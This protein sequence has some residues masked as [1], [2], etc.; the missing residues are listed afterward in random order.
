MTPPVPAQPPRVKGWCPGSLRPMMSG[1]GLVLRIKISGGRLDTGMLRAIAALGRRTGNGL[2]DLSHRANL[3]MRGLSDATVPEAL[4][5]LGRLGLLP[6]DEASE[7]VLNVVAPPLAGCDPR[8]AVDGR[9]IVEALEAM[10]RA[11][12]ALHALPGK[13]GFVVDDGA[14]LATTG[15]AADIAI[16]A[17]VEQGAAGVA[18]RLA[19]AAHVAARVAPELA[20]PS[21]GAL[22]RAFLALRAPHDAR[23]M[24]SLVSATGAEHIFAQA[25]L[26]VTAHAPR[27]AANSADVLGAHAL[28]QGAFVG[29][30]AAF[31]RWRADDL[32]AFAAA[33][34]AAGG[35]R[36]RLTPWRALLAVD[37]APASAAGLARSLEGLGL[38]VDASDPL[39]RVAAC[40]GAPDCGS[41]SVG[42]HALA[43]A[44]A[45]LL[46]GAA[47][48]VL[49]VSGC[50]KGCAHPRPAALTLVGRDGAFDLVVDGAPDAGPTVRGLDADAA[51]CEIARRM[52]NTAAS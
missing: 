37:L 29:A 3:Q 18:L 36:L 49:H 22:A 41:A 8:A 12:R 20:A 19:G 51:R 33:V 38:I 23:R 50:P 27:A 14:G 34:E 6:P 25:G 42:T 21:A 24:R 48:L 40:P 11:D 47:G 35:R 1:D 10:L 4:D 13:F 16:E 30:A 15:V 43:R 45:P 39:L 7:Q 32:D 2:F 52:L 17:V 9:A 44:C 26:P 46:E 5:E 28:G 31:G